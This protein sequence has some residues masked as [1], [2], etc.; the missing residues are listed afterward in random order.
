MGSTK[1][2]SRRGKPARSSS[3]RTSSGSGCRVIPRRTPEPAG[4]NVDDIEKACAD[5]VI[6]TQAFGLLDRIA[7]TARRSQRVRRHSTTMAWFGAGASPSGVLPVALRGTV[8]LLRL[9]GIVAEQ[10]RGA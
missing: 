6:M 10:Q 2:G 7:L 3:P 5:L 8:E 4:A 1:S 9:R